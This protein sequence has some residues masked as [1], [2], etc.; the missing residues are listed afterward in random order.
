MKTLLSLDV[1]TTAVKAGLFAEDLSPLGLVIEEY[2]LQT[3]GPDLVEMDPEI[4]WQSACRSI[5]RVIEN[6]DV[7]A[8]SVQVIT[9]TTQGETMIPVDAAGTTLHPAIVWLD[10][11]AREEA[12]FLSAR[13]TAEEF[14]QT[15]G[16]PEISSYCPVA[17]L[18]WLKDRKPDI[19]DR[20]YKLLLLE[21]YLVYRLTGQFV[22]NP[23]LQSS[24]GYFDI[25]QGRYWEKILTCCGL[26]SD[27]LPKLLP[28]GTIV[29]PIRPELADAFGLSPS[30]LVSTGA[31]DQVAAAVGC[32]NIREGVVTDTIGTCQVVAATANH[33]PDLPWSAVTVYAHA[34][35]GKYLLLLINQTAGIVLKWFRN[36]FCRDLVDHFGDGA[37]DEMGRLASQIPPLSRGLTLFPQFTGIQGAVNNPDVRGAFVGVGLDTDRACF[38]RAVMEG[39]CYM[40]RQSIETMELS[41]ETLISLG[42]GAKSSIWNQVKADITGKIVSILQVEEAALLGA[43]MLGGLACGILNSLEH[44]AVSRSFTPNRD[45]HDAYEVGYQRY[46]KLYDCLRPLFGEAGLK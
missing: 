4:Y 18:K 21:D 27:K 12:E 9:C 45:N 23:S 14:Y 20:T 6:V 19:Y 10:A 15:T 22:S 13:F 32:G 42:G 3:P 43:A 8:T 36:E 46:C 26:D 16:L 24:T 35:P 5:R 7:D 29:S 25:H 1:G 11:R 28:C 39:V 40:S 37:F 2:T 33:A 41:P 44:S 38:I 31:M 30:T 34:I 17:K